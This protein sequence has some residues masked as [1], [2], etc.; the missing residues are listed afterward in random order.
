MKVRLRIP[1]TSSSWGDV[2]RQKP[3]ELT[4]TNTT[5]FTYS[6]HGIIESAFEEMFTA[7]DERL[8]EE[9]GAVVLNR[10]GEVLLTRVR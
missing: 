5:L 9:L 6:L 3:A 1:S 2:I 7:L 8:T 4:G 10:N